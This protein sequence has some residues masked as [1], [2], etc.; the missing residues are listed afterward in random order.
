[1]LYIGNMRYIRKERIH[2]KTLAAPAEARG[3]ALRAMV[4]PGYR[5][6][7]KHELEY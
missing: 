6:A 3:M 7:V 2:V 5:L 1:M 4:A